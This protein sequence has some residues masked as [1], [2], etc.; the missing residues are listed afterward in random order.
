MS[1]KYQCNRLKMNK[2]K[3]PTFGEIIKHIV[4]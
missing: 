1:A 4:D 2:T 3:F